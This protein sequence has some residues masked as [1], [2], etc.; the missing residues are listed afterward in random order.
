M[1]SGRRVGSGK[2]VFSTSAPRNKDGL[3]VIGGVAIIQTAR[4]L[5]WEIVISVGRDLWSLV[6][7][8]D[9]WPSQ[10]WTSD[11]AT[12][13]DKPKVRGSRIPMNHRTSG[14]QV[15][16][17]EVGKGAEK[18]SGGQSIIRPQQESE[19]RKRP[20]RLPHPPFHA[21]NCRH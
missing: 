5:R 1:S 11:V 8:R 7:S 10:R 18:I 14:L 21:F 2:V 19:K 20:L 3:L 6:S 4:I 12:A 16:V 15:K 13:G 17:R 9:R